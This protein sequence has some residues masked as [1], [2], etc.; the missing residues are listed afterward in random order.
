MIAIQDPTPAVTEPLYL[1][2]CEL[3]LC[4]ACGNIGLVGQTGFTLTER[5]GWFRCDG[6]EYQFGIELTH[7]VPSVIEPGVLS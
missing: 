6:C 5:T 1:S 4:P 2:F 7:R 3:F